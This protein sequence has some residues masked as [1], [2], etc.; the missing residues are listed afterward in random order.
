MRDGDAEYVYIYSD[1]PCV[2]IPYVNKC[3]V[4]FFLK[5]YSNTFKMCYEMCVA[6]WSLNFYEII[7]DLSTISFHLVC[8]IQILLTPALFIYVYLYEFETRHEFHTAE[9]FINHQSLLSRLLYM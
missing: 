5:L 9:C 8:S 3:S 6:S 2:A 1:V 4:I 7:S